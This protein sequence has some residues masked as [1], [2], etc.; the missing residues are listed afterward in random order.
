MF[1]QATSGVVQFLDLLQVLAISMLDSRPTQLA[2]RERVAITRP[3][4]IVTPVP[5]HGF[6]TEFPCSWVQLVWEWAMWR[7][8][9]SV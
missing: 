6:I 7:L 8:L 1:H 2:H 9:K 3:K 5:Q 4:S